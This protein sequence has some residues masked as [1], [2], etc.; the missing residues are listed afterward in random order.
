MESVKDTNKT[1]IINSMWY[2]VSQHV[3]FFENRC[4]GFCGSL[5]GMQ[6][7]YLDKFYFSIYIALSLPIIVFFFFY[8]CCYCFQ[9]KN[10]NQKV[11]QNKIKSTSKNKQTYTFICEFRIVMCNLY[12]ANPLVYTLFNGF[13][14]WRPLNCDRKMGCFFYMYKQHHIA[15]IICSA[16]FKRLIDFAISKSQLKAI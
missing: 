15:I 12:M 6:K 16:P 11:L 5:N 7:R 14:D 9:N 4:I 10:G 3:L 8:F 13:I 2:L 1:I